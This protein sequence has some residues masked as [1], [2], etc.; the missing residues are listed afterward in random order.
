M[1]ENHQ[2]IQANGRTYHYSEH[3]LSR[4]DTRFGDAEEPA[5]YGL[6]VSYISNVLDLHTGEFVGSAWTI[7]EGLAIFRARRDYARFVEIELLDAAE[8]LLPHLL[9]DEFGNACP[10]WPPP[11]WAPQ[12]SYDRDRDVMRLFNDEVATTSRPIT[13]NV[14]IGCNN[15]GKPAYVEILGAAELLLP[16]LLPLSEEVTPINQEVS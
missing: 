7:S 6:K 13:D 12:V 14:T 8:T 11:G 4:L 9:P 3:L 5:D 16:Y 15:E 2:E 10:S 1:S